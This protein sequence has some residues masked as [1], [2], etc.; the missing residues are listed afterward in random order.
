MYIDRNYIITLNEQRPILAEFKNGRKVEYTT[1]ILN[2]LFTDK[3]VVCVSDLDTGEII[4]CT[5]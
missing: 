5:L 3:E 1:D 2:L 4:F